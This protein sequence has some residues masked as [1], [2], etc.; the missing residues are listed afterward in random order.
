L[1]R[2]RA[3]QAL[4]EQKLKQS[5]EAAHKAK[6]EAEKKEARAVQGYLLKARLLTTQFQ[7][8]QAEKV[9]ES[10]IQAAPESFDVHFAFGSF[11]Q[12]LNHFSEARREYS[13]A[14]KIARR[15]GS[16]SD[17]AETLNKLGNL[18]EA[19]NRIEE[20]RQH[21]DEALQAYRQEAQRYPKAYLAYAAETLD[22]LAA[23]DWEQNRM[24]E[25]RQHYD[26]ALKTY[27]SWRSGSLIPTCV[28]RPKR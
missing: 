13:L 20:A 22:N 23:L 1:T 6:L 21:F 17:L 10:A 27:Y 19:Q 12:D 14:M 24:S 4:D 18:D 28:M 2:D 25:A 15:T 7:F 5:I 26:E 8:V 11:G 16:E 3:L 9:Y